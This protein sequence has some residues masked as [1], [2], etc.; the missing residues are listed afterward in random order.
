M[1]PETL[2]PRP[3]IP[4]Q[5]VDGFV[6]RA[7]RTITDNRRESFGVRWRI[8]TYRAGADQWEFQREGE[9]LLVFDEWGQLP[10]T[11]NEDAVRAQMIFWSEQDAV[12]AFIA[13]GHKRVEA[14]RQE[15]S[16]IL[17][18]MLNRGRRPAGGSR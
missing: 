11:L 12:D 1:N 18:M 3:E 6:V 8:Y 2:T 4:A 7:W 14:L 9:P 5:P 16:T 10:Y 15:A 17:A 13:W